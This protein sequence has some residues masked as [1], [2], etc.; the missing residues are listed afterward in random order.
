MRQAVF[1]EGDQRKRRVFVYALRRYYHSD[2]ACGRSLQAGY[3]EKKPL[4]YLTIRC[5]NYLY[6][7]KLRRSIFRSQLRQETEKRDREDTSLKRPYFSR[8]AQTRSLMIIYYYSVFAPQKVHKQCFF[9]A[10]AL[11]II[12]TVK[13]R[14]QGYFLCVRSIFRSTK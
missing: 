2:G 4:D 8:N 10:K 11:H 6:D 3:H 13:T 5:G 14:A 1:D 7:Q 12:Y 9:R